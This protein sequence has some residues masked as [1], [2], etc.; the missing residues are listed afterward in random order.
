MNTPRAPKPSATSRVG[1]PFKDKDGRVISDPRAFIE[2]LIPVQGGHYLLGAHGFFH[3]GIHLDRACKAYLSMEDGICCLAD[4]EVIAYRIDSDYHD[5]TPGGVGQ[6]VA[7]RPYSTGFVLVRHRLQAPPPPTPPKP[8]PIEAPGTDIRDW[9]T[10]LYADR[11]GRQPIAWLRHG[12]PLIV[13]VGTYT[14][15]ESTLVRVTDTRDATLPREGWICRRHLALDPAA[16]TGLRAVLGLKDTV[17]TTVYHGDYV[18]PDKS[19]AYTE[20]K[21]QRQRPEPL[22]APVLTLYSLYMHVASRGDYGRNARWQRPSWWLQRDGSREPEAMDRVVAVSPPVPIH[23]GDLI[24]Y[25]G[26]D[27]PARAYPI[28]GQPVTRRLLHL[29]IFSGDDLPAY[30]SASR[31]WA[32]ENLPESERTLLLLMAGDVLQQDDG[33]TL[34]VNQRQILRAGGLES[35]TTDGKRWRKVMLGAAQGHATGWIEEAGRLVSPWE[36][37]GFEI[38]DEVTSP[39]GFRHDAPDAFAEYLRGE[40]PRPPDTPFYQALRALVDRNRDGVFSEEELDRLLRNRHHADRITRIIARHETAWTR[41]SMRGY[42]E[43]A[44]RI[45]VKLGP[46]AVDNVDAEAPRAEMLPWWEDVAAGVEGFPASSRVWHLHPGGVAGNFSGGS[47]LFTVTMLQKVFPRAHG[48]RLQ[49]IASELNSNID[50][51]EL[52]TA[53]RRTHFFAQVAQEAGENLAFEE[54]LN[55]SASSLSQFAYFKRLPHEATLYGRTSAHGA[56]QRAIADRIYANRIGNGDVASGDGWRFRGRGLKQ[57]T[58]RANYRAFTAWHRRVFPSELVD[59]EQQPDLLATACYAT[60]SAAYF[61]EGN[62]LHLKAD[63]GPTSAVVDSI[64]RVV[65][66]YTDSYVARAKHFEDMWSKGLFK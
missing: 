56:D 35:R 4:G 12:T 45:A 62:G 66:R 58:G 59:F 48:N 23:Q 29:E 63:D 32:K 18:D 27:V 53:L 22:A 37:P 60:R 24:G 34:T 26:E 44:R 49:E 14:P 65:N 11:Q 15:G 30:L 36:W 50:R 33:G 47:F 55:Y 3:G 7:W 16:G 25:L 38:H 42:A 57:L 51:F 43:T 52:D 31:R 19:A 41:A 1:Y 46:V 40:G 21:A 13:Q 64:T 10:H 5:A 39:D 61:W 2:A 54:G 20:N 28:A 6:G 8:P 9:G 17:V